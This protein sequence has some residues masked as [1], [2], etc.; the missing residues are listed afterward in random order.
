MVDLLGLASFIPV[1]SAVV[2]PEVFETDNPI[3]NI[4][5]W[6]EID[7]ERNFLIL[8][9]CFSLV[10]FLFRAGFII[11]SYWFQNKFVYA[12]NEHIGR[13]TYLY[14][15]N[16]DYEEFQNR[17]SSKIF[18]ELTINPRHFTSFLVLPLLLLTT[19]LTIIMMIVTGIAIYDYKVFLLLVMTIVP[20]S[21]IFNRL[22]K[23]K[24][25]RYGTEQ[26]ELTPIWYNKS[27]RGAFGFIDVKLRGKEN[28]LVDD[29]SHYLNRLNRISLITTIL[30]IIPA[31]MFELATVVGLLIIFGYSIFI[32][33]DT[34]KVIPLIAV[35]AASGYRVLPSLSKVIASFLNIEKYSYLFNI[36]SDPLKS[37]ISFED[38]NEVSLSFKN[39]IKIQDL[40]FSFKG[41]KELLF[42]N[43]SLEVKHAEIVGLIGKSG[44]G[45]TTLVKLLIGLLKPS[46]GEIL[47]DGIPLNEDNIGDWMAGISYVQQAPYLE[48]GNLQSNIAFLEKEVDQER[49]NYAIEKASLSEF[50]GKR[51][52]KDV[53]I[54][55]NGKNLSGGQKQRVIIARALYHRSK[56]I[57][58]D[59]AT[60]A[61]DNETEEE[62]NETIKHLKGSGVTIIIIAHRHSTLKHTDRIIEI[63]LGKISTEYKYDELIDKGRNTYV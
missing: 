7:S 37:N 50:V 28:D 51:D 59:E 44:S 33:N 40:K 36:F 61:L 24:V 54:D 49:M 52:P 43:V 16:S 27:N 22:V 25:V 13:K 1:I 55:E 41:Q 21:F 17:D 42:D 9:I 12:L 19:E 20:I 32:L 15:L 3:N 57:V 10:F 38:R 60:S 47:V 6:L 14:Y 5:N 18:R 2:N 58:M 39:D 4:K 35:Y 56:L 26:N 31:K 62:V 45:K 11:F 63:D 53:I 34:N 30:G 48:K 46:G 8:L 23:K 29:Y